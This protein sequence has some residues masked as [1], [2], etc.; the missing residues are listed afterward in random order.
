MSNGYNV[1][2]N[3]SEFDLQD[4]DIQECINV[5]GI[6]EVLYQIGFDKEYKSSDNTHNFYQILECE[7]V[8]RTGKR[9]FG[10][11]FI[12]RERTDKGWLDSGLASEDAKMVARKDISYLNQIKNLSKRSR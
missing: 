4:E 3:I 8:T 10:K 2:T 1:Y 12:S 5:L 11:L 6:D 9:V 7:H